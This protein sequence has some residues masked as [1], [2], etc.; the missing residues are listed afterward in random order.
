[1]HFL[2]LMTIIRITH[3]SGLILGFGGA[4]LA[5]FT[6]FSRGVIRPVSPYTIYQT[7]F[8]S[9]LVSFGLVILW[10]SGIALI[11]INLKDHP[12]YLTNQKLWAKVAIVGILTLNGILIHRKILPLLKRSVGSRLFD[13][14]PRKFIGGLT[15]LGSISIVSWSI[16][17]VLGKASELNYVTPFWVIMSAYAVCVLTAWLTLYT[18]MA[19]ICRLQYL[20]R[21]TALKTLQPNARWEHANWR[22][23]R[24]TVSGDGRDE[25]YLGEMIRQS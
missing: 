14:I 11:W 21:S 23:S 22:R 7:E 24:K 2:T 3:L 5:D 6:I 20:V 1:M 15:L 13:D 4:V 18:V 16:P 9:R 12:E 17:F 25:E 10:F 8:L 19:S